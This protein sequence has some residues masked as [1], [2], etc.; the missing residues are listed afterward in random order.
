MRFFIC[1]FNKSPF[2]KQVLQNCITPYKTLS[3]LLFSCLS[4]A[5]HAQDSEIKVKDNYP[6]ALFAEAEK[7][8]DN[9]AWDEANLA[10]DQAL[11]SIDT[12]NDLRTYI[13]YLERK[14]EY[15]RRGVSVEKG[16]PYIQKAYDLAKEHLAADDLLLSRVYHRVGIFQYRLN[17]D[18]GARSLFDTTFVLYQKASFYDSLLYKDIIDYKYYSY[19]QTGGSPDTVIK[20]IDERRKYLLSTNP[21]PD[22]YDVLLLMQDNTDQ[23]IRKGDLEKALSLAIEAY[24]YALEEEKRIVDRS[25]GL[26]NR[27]FRVYAYSFSRLTDVLNNRGDFQ[28]ALEIGLEREQLM[29]KWEMTPN[30]YRDYYAV[31]KSIGSALAG[32]NRNEEALAYYNEALKIGT[33]DIVFATF[34]ARTKLDKARV[35]S[36]MGMLEMALSEVNECFNIYKSIVNRSSPDYSPIY[37]TRGELE[38]ANE[39]YN[40]AFLDYD[41]AIRSAIPDMARNPFMFPKD[42]LQ[43]LNLSNLNILVKKS[44]LMRRL[45]IDTLSKEQLASYSLNYAEM[46]HQILIERRGEFTATEGKLF[47]SRVFRDLYEGAIQATF[48]I[49]QITKDEDNIDMALKFFQRSKSNLFLEQ[50]A[51]LEK[52]NNNVIDQALK[53]SFS[54]NKARIDSLEAMFYPMLKSDVRSDSMFRVNEALTE[55]RKSEVDIMNAIDA[56]LF[57]ARYVSDFQSEL[58]LDQLIS[59]MGD[60]ELLIEYFFGEEDIYLLAISKDSKELKKLPN[61]DLLSQEISSLLKILANPPDIS[62]FEAGQLQYHQ[63]AHS[64]YRQLLHPVLKEKTNISQLIIVPDEVLARLPFEA[65]VTDASPTTF[66]QMNFLINNYRVQYGLTSAII[67]QEVEKKASK[68]ILGLGFSNTNNVL[69]WANLPGTEREIK[70]LQAAYDGTY[71]TAAKKQDFIDMS[72]EYDVLHLAVHGLADTLSKRDAKLVFSEGQE[73]EL[74]TTD[75]YMASINARLAVLSACQSGVGAIQKGEGT[76]SIARGFAVTGVPAIVMSLWSVNDNITSGLMTEMYASFINDNESINSALRSTKLNYLKQA[77]D[78]QAHPYYWAAFIQL[79]EDIEY[80]A[81]MNKAVPYL[82][83]AFFSVFCFISIWFYLSRRKA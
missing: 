74:N 48:D 70:S 69:R 38:E 21:S 36:E 42:S 14:S 34:Y 4:I 1:N 59:K 15:T 83:Y 49:Y 45:T 22:P 50:Q 61:K 37:E 7:L 5:L 40:A 23:H 62:A 81:E 35:Y 24:K 56:Q 26:F 8:Y 43:E 31:K 53:L 60:N 20:Y 2:H 44:R 51:E 57:E 27:R 68:S 39:N 72:S 3:I 71:L 17:N 28:E 76:F 12:V 25:D 19:Y 10:I 11:Q 66:G 64:L 30:T 29:K 6:P 80:E 32:L 47:L 13:V 63:L 46:I 16:L 78:Y 75:L 77:D 9:R 52:V 65:L 33:E 82:L 58:N 41:S 73:N 55:S 54:S 67:G 18:F 79:G